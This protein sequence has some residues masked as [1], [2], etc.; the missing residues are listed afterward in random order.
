MGIAIENANAF[1]KVYADGKDVLRK[2]QQAKMFKQG[3]TENFGYKISYVLSSSASGVKCD[4]HSG[5]H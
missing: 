1:V 5:E 2:A 3:P 4:Q